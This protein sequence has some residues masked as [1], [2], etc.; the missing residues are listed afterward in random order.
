MIGTAVAEFAT[1]PICAIRTNV[2]NIYSMKTNASIIAVTRDL[3]NKEGLKSF[4]RASFPAI[5]GQIVSTSSKYTLYHALNNSSSYPIKNTMINGMTAGIISTIITHPLDVWK[6]TNQMN[7]SLFKECQ[8]IGLRLL[9]RG[10]SKTLLKTSIS[11]SMF[12]PFYD[13]IKEN[14]ASP[15]LASAISSTISTTIM[16]PIDYLKTRHIN[17]LP[18]YQGTH[19][20][21]YYR[22]LSLSLL[23][24]VPHFMITMTTI[25]Y[26]KKKFNF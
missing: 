5:F 6:V 17:G 25:E 13:Y 23:R 7:K 18:L 3:Y 9:Y 4:Y 19:I 26:I 11:G 15:M 12:L 14:V 8:L 20:L 21:H 1:L 24:I 22:G 16:H 2:Q 10:Y